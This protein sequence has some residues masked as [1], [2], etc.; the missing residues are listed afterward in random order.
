MPITING[1]GEIISGDQAVSKTM[2]VSADEDGT[3][4]LRAVHVRWTKDGAEIEV[5]FWRGWNTR[6]IKINKNHQKYSVIND[7]KICCKEKEYVEGFMGKI[8]VQPNR[9][10]S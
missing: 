10:A 1:L 5:D 6:V 3:A 7:C 8:N 9:P 2:R 4:L